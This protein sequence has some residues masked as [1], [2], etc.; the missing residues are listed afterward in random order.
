MP[1]PVVATGI[2]AINETMITLGISG[3]GL[4]D[5][6][7]FSKSD[8]Y[9]VISKPDARGLYSQVR[10][11]ETK[12]N[13]LDPDWTDILV[14]ETELCGHDHN[15]KLKFEVF[16][17]DGKQGV[18]D[19]KDKLIGEGFFSLKQLQ[20]AQTVK[21][22]LQLLNKKGKSTGHL[23]VRV[24]KMH[25]PGSNRS[26]VH[27]AQHGATT[28]T[29]TTRRS[30]RSSSS[31]D[32]KATH[33]VSLPMSAQPKR[34]VS[35]GSLIDS[36]SS[37]SS[38]PPPIPHNK[39][40]TPTT[41]SSQGT[42]ISLGISGRSLKDQDVFSKSDPYMTLSRP[43][44]KGNYYQVKTTETLNNNLN[45]DWAE[46][47][48]N[49]YELC[50]YD[51]NMKIRFDV[52]DDDG[53]AGADKKDKLIGEGYFTLNQIKAAQASQSVLQLSNKGKSTGKLQV[54]SF[55]IL[56]HG[57]K[58]PTPTTRHK[59]GTIISLGI[60]GR[61]LKDQD[62]FSKSD[63][64]MTLSRPDQ[65]GIYYQVKT[66]ETLNNNLNPDWT[67]ILIDEYELCGNDHNMKIR[68]DVFDDDGKTGADK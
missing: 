29:T 66:T 46:I 54:R 51:H 50:G 19:K 63:P 60:S 10:V 52:F 2:K 27:S 32:E 53:K 20:A 28:T 26:P 5:L 33:R 7:V 67:E 6:D 4:K 15:L 38:T 48:I 61:S 21:S 58:P 47:L 22:S 3:R 40:P 16:D 30:R 56:E 1:E 11:S 14:S 37:H 64:Y 34:S 55:K 65:K 18:Q 23:I 9:L 49:E 17:D 25:E 57:T 12:K 39:P 31:E 35:N 44:Q 13:N 68:F 43:D 24:F 62:V 36:Q 42:I 45:P 59:Q 41:R 8:P